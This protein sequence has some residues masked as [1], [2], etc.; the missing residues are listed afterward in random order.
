MEFLYIHCYKIPKH[1]Y[2]ARCFSSNFLEVSD[3][4]Q[5]KVN[6]A[7]KE[8]QG[9]K[10]FLQLT[11]GLIVKL[12]TRLLQ[13]TGFHLEVWFCFLS[14]RCP[15]ASQKPGCSFYC[16]LLHRTLTVK[17]NKAQLLTEYLLL[18]RKEILSHYRSLN[19]FARKR[20][21]KSFICKQMQLIRTY[22]TVN[23]NRLERLQFL[24]A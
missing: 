23:S 12:S 19:S 1:K 14:S 11:G 4:Q 13:L 24:T 17:V 7:C 9:R 18:P 10:C 8:G 6:Q 3:A 5:L 2:F 15:L 22:V 21:V 16:Y 20:D